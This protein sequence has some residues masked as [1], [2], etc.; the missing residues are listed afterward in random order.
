MSKRRL[1]E[2]SDAVEQLSALE[3]VMAWKSMQNCANRLSPLVADNSAD[4]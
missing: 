1:F 2:M 3:R 4:K